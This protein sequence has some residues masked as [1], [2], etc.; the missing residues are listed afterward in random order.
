MLSKLIID[1]VA[2]KMKNL[3]DD[4]ADLSGLAESKGISMI[5]VH[6]ICYDSDY[7]GAVERA[8]VM[9]RDQLAG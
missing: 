2:A 9:Y 4:M 3:R 6:D 5:T 7:D 8:W 1:D